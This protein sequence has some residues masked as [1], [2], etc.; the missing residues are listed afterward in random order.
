MKFSRKGLK[1]IRLIRLEKKSTN[2]V[3]KN[4]KKRKKLL[5][6]KNLTSIKELIP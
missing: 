3:K 4:W 5:V 6:S 2:F 1:E